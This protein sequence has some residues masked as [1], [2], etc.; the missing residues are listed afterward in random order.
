MVIRGGLAFDRV[1]DKLIAITPRN[2]AWP[3]SASAY[4]FLFWL[5]PN[6]LAITHKFDLGASGIDPRA[7]AVNRA[8]WV[9]VAT[10][11]LA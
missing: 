9:A 11:Y 5:D 2:N 10:E 7:V 4:A 8:G 3:G 6:T 1:T